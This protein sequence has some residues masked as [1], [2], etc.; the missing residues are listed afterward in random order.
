MYLLDQGAAMP[1]PRFSLLPRCLSYA[2]LAASLLVLS[3]CAQDRYY[4]PSETSASQKNG[5]TVYG[6]IDTSVVRTR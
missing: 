5:V 4:Q 2:A 6:E 1:S 3:G